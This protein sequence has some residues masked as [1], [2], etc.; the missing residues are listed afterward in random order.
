[1]VGAPLMIVKNRDGRFILGSLYLPS[2]SMT[3]T[4]RLLLR[5]SNEGSF[6]PRAPQAQETVGACPL[7][8]S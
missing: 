6:R 5:T 4:N 7:P 2:S 3:G 1:M 8:F